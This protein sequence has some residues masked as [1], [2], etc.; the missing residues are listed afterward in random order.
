MVPILC[1][2][3][4]QRMRRRLSARALF[5]TVSRLGIEKRASWFPPEG[6]GPDDE[7][8]RLAMRS[9]NAV[10]HGLARQAAGDLVIGSLEPGERRV[11]LHLQ[12]GM[13]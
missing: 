4:D 8:P 2:G 13:I 11:F 10:R 1:R 9:D 7:R 5:M 3:P 6:R 12:V